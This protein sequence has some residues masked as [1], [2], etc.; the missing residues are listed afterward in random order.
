[1]Q[2]FKSL[3]HLTHATNQLEDAFSKKFEMKKCGL[4]MGDAMGDRVND[5]RTE[6]VTIEFNSEIAEHGD[7]KSFLGSLKRLEDEWDHEA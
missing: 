5:G 4:G 1:M 2:L 3:H 6:N 7:W